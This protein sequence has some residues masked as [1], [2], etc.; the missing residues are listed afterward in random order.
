M[1]TQDIPLVNTKH[2]I[3]SLIPQQISDE[4]LLEKYAKGSEKSQLDVRRRVAQALARLE[5]ESQRQTWEAQFLT[6]QEQGFIPAGRISSAAGT[7]LQATLI[8]CFVQPVGDSITESV[9]GRPGIYTAL[10]Q[11]AETMRRGGGVGMTFPQFDQRG[12]KSKAHN[13]APVVLS[14]ICASL[15]VRVK[16]SNPQAHDV[17]HK[18]GYYV[19]T[20]PTLSCLFT[21]KIKVI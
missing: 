1:T 10:A 8:N 21:P 14:P 4:V 11:A 6:A 5:P 3:S 15:T 16:P 7:A 18:W 12:Q 17:A 13:H 19:V 9:A 20:T 2:T